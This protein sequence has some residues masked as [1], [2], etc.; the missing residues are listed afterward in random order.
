M[1]QEFEHNVKTFKTFAYPNKIQTGFKRE[2]EVEPENRYLRNA[3]SNNSKGSYEISRIRRSKA[4]THP[5][6]SDFEFQ[7]SEIRSAEFH[8][9][10]LVYLSPPIRNPLIRG[11][12][13]SINEWRELTSFTISSCCFSRTRAP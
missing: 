8:G 7:T 4:S 2:N 1:I 13:G 10:P 3:K 6:S 11:L 9:L 5:Q 12:R